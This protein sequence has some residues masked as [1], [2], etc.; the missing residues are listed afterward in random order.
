[1][2]IPEAA[3]T[4][5]QAQQ[6][7]ELGAQTARVASSVLLGKL[8]IFLLTGLSF[9]I[10]A[11][12]LGPSTYGIYTLAVAIIGIFGS[13]GDLGIGVSFNKFLPEY[14]QRNDRGKARELLKN[15]F[16]VLLAFGGAL[17]A[18][19][20]LLAGPFSAYVYHTISNVGLIEA[21]AFLILL[22][23]V[24]GDAY[25]ALIGL[26]KGKGIAVTAGIESA[27]QA[28]ASVLFALLGYGA[29]SPIFGLIA[30]YS[31]GII[32]AMLYIRKGVAGGSAGRISLHRI[33][34]LFGFSLPI[35]VSNLLGTLFSN[36]SLVVLG[37]FAT[38]VVI[39]NFGVASK[40][41]SLIDLITGSISVSLITMFSAALTLKRGKEEIAKFYNY[42][43]YLAFLLVTPLLFYIGVLAKP[44][45]YVAFSGVYKLS[46]TYIAIMAFGIFL[47]L[48]GTYSY[49]LMVSANKVRSVLKYTIVT[50][51]VELALLPILVPEFKGVG[52]TLLLF[53]VA[54]LV[55]DVLYINGIRRIFNIRIKSA[56]IIRVIAANAVSAAFIA[57]VALLIGEMMIPTLAISALIFIA[58]YPPMLVIVRAMEERDIEIVKRSTSGVP[59]IG[60]VIGY[61]LD[62]S[63]L[64][65]RTRA[66]HSRG[67]S[68]EE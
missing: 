42:S 54:P 39:G 3:E 64:F 61:L 2:E 24:Y 40:T 51:A 59:V 29:F 34:E 30:G 50:T 5:S 26:R 55:G 20:F 52:L 32:I 47:G 16:A 17:T 44:L 11:R 15:G 67:S 18:A 60:N 7:M 58:V 4:G 68:S 43:L 63:R 38:S 65:L 6:S 35:G 23:I 31:S 62:Y 12:I 66:A 45:S 9:V 1:M 21:A 22:S 46:P 27:I 53:M 10:V 13:V 49:N 57:V 33:K 14:M 37:L 25:S 48:V 56:K 19:M 8:V 36:A 28:G 41:G